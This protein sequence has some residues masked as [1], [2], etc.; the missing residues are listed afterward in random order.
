[1]EIGGMEIT[2]DQIRLA[3]IFLPY[4]VERQNIVQS[5]GIRFVHYTRADAAM[6]ILKTKTVWMRKTSCMND[7]MEVEHGLECL[8]EAYR[9]E[10]GNRL[11]TAL[12]DIFD[13][14][15][16]EIEKLFNSWQPHFRTDTYIH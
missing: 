7:F 12:N 4:A 10:A 15:S 14:V 5:N 8:A 9:G 13:G 2:P 16:D 11:K 1:M 3:G 6:N